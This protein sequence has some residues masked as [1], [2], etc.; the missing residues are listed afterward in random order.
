VSDAEGGSAPLNDFDLPTEEQPIQSE[1]APKIDTSGE[2]PSE[3]EEP[4]AEGP[5]EGEGEE[6]EGFLQR[7]AK[8]NPYVVLLGVS[9]GAVLLAL[10]FL[11]MELAGYS[12]DIK[13][14]KGKEGALRMPPAVQS[15]PASTIAA[16]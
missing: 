7:L 16:A 15:A 11:F 6:K 14:K 9:L 13:A 8:A 1:E 2:K 5:E 12:F 10:L 3:P 4:V